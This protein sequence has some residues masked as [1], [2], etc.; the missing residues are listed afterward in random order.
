MP[1]ENGATAPP[2]LPL[3]TFFTG[4]DA[5]RE[6]VP[7][8]IDRG[9]WRTQSGAGQAQIMITLR[10]FGLVDDS[11]NPN[12]LLEK[13]AKADE[14]ERKKLLKPLVEQHYKSIIAHD[15]TKM[16]P[17]MLDDEIGAAFGLNG[18]TRRKA[19]TFLLQ[20]AKYLEMPL[21]PFLSDQTRA[22]P[23]RRKPRTPRANKI[24][25]PA[26]GSEGQPFV[27][28]SG[29]SST[30]VELHGGGTITMIV[31]ADVWKMPP[32]DRAFVL[33]L[34][35]KIQGYAQPAMQPENDSEDSP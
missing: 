35:D 28:P 13:I 18:D 8:K 9:I 19:I 10:F 22:T 15:L 31:T 33:E 32:D 1:N 6:G 30:Q 11:D 2:Y 3:K 7:K 14:S 20:M 12:P 21:S 16:T 5:L 25:S 23:S 17:K 34:V 24:T 4:L 27:A 26:P 29:G